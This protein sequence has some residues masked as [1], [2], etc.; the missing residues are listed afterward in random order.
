MTIYSAVPLPKLPAKTSPPNPEAILYLVDKETDYKIRLDYLQKLLIKGVVIETSGLATG[1]INDETGTGTINVP[2]ATQEQAEEG[3]NDK[4]ALTPYSGALQINKM[5]PKATQ[6]MVDEG[7]DDTAYITAFLLKYYVDSLDIDIEYATVDAPG[8]IQ[9]A[10]NAEAINGSNATKSLTPST[11]LAQLVSRISGALD[12]T[13]TDYNASEYALSLVNTKAV[14][15]QSTANAAQAALD[16]FKAE[17]NPFPQY[18]HNDEHATQAQAEEGTSAGVWMSPLRVAQHFLSKLSD[19]IDGTSHVLSATEYALGLV[20]AKAQQALDEQLHWVKV[21]SGSCSLP[22]KNS[23]TG[24]L[25]GT[26]ETGY[27][28]SSRKHYSGRFKVNI[29][30]GGEATSTD[31]TNCWWAFRGEPREVTYWSG[32]PKVLID[33][34]GYGANLQSGTGATSWELWELQA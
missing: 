13:R 27:S 7:I 20:N 33:V 16:S 14:N 11:G 31:P 32:T 5:R 26:I 9:L 10:T 18:L 23:T 4:V 6:E 8:I 28:V 24:A 22:W 1:G 34:Y 2:K 3:V 29:I 19:K 12:G 21:A 30:S 15:A 25:V 17:D